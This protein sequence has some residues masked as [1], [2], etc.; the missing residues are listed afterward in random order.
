MASKF[1][2]N[3]INA[4]KHILY[5]LSFI[6]LWNISFGQ[7][8]LLIKIAGE[9]VKSFQVSDHK[10][11]GEGWEF[12]LDEVEK[13]QHFLVGEDHFSNEI[14]D[15]IKAIGSKSRFDNFF[16]EVDPYT[17]QLIED[18]FTKMSPEE[19]VEFTERYSKYYSFYALKPE[20]ELLEYFMESGI[21]LLG[22]DQIIMYGEQLLFPQLKA[23]NSNPEVKTF[24]DT[25]IHRSELQLEKFFE[26]T[27]NP[28]YFITPAFTEDLDKLKTM[29]ISDTEQ[30]IIDNMEQSIE[31][32]Q[33]LSHS[34]RVKLIIRQLMDEYEV[35]K[36]SRTLF[37]YGANHLMR[38]ESLLTVYDI[39]NVVANITEAYGEQS[40][41]LMIVGQSGMLGSP[42]KGF[43]SQKVDKE[44]GFYLSFL[45]PFFP[46]TAGNDWYVFDLRPIRKA[47]NRRKV[48]IDNLSL[49]RVIK[50]YDLLVII[51]EVTPAGFE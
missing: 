47:L 10:Y 37:K 48:E 24:Y 49:K 26:D 28:M 45:K 32:Y 21:N 25:I 15:F 9:H 36:D 14:P 27:S 7:D 38:G 46:L 1:S 4:M 5:T 17:T 22:S 3:Q 50:G 42:F 12:I 13:S 16:I 41:H 33:K 43:P 8:S 29:N 44:N 6:L 40:L 34:I 11:S 35:W 18:S 19:R 39:G 23:M 20:F 2:L 31:I 30:E 51:P